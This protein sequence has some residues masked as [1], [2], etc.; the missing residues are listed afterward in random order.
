MRLEQE[1]S[2]LLT[3]HLQETQELKE[4]VRRLKTQKSATEL[5]IQREEARALKEAC[6]RSVDMNQNYSNMVSSLK[7]ENLALKEACVRFVD[8]N[9]KYSNIV[10]ESLQRAMTAL[11]E[12]RRLKDSTIREMEENL[13]CKKRNLRRQAETQSRILEALNDANMDLEALN[14]RM[15][16][17]GA[18]N[19]RLHDD[20]DDD[21]DEEELQTGTQDQEPYQREEMEENLAEAW[22]QWDQMMGIKWN[23]KPEPVPPPPCPCCPSCT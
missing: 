16:I 14:H 10:V 3:A 13:L 9:Q 15:K 11:E 17:L 22:A 1:R 19:S 6:V 2:H 4:E 20:E 7:E 21:D 12:E 23:C 18:M 5:Q 8:K